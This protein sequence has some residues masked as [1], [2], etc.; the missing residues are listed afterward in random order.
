NAANREVADQL[1]AL[2]EQLGGVFNMESY[3]E[4]GAAFWEKV[5]AI[6]SYDL[7]QLLFDDAGNFTIEKINELIK[8]MVITDQEVI[9][10]VDHYEDLLGKLNEA[11][12]Q[13]QEL[14]TATMA[15][16]IAD[17]IIDGFSQGFDSV[18]DFAE[19]FEELMKN[20]ILN[21]LKIQ[22]LEEPLKEWYRQFA[23]A[24]ETGN[25]LTEAEIAS[26]EDS[27]NQIVE[28][29]R[30]Q[31][32]EMQRIANLDFSAEVAGR[33]GLQGAIKGITEETA[34]LIAGQ[35]TAMREI[36]Q[37]SYLTGLEQLD[38]INQ[39]VTHLAHI[40]ENTRYNRH[41]EEIRDDIKNMNTYL[42]NAL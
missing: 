26:L 33:E 21:A 7:D 14:L 8:K 12:T 41:L 2:Q 38:A 25:V 23:A 17:G 40:E 1:K 34:G 15:D 31:F 42:K 35:F 30:V 10:V 37:K 6:Y 36:G 27:Y 24:S 9:N 22:T 4:V 28:N 39:S 18:A 16:N 5:K 29:A 32:D 13:K 11:E 20:A 3:K 19:G